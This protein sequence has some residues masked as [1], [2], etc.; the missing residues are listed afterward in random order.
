MALSPLSY[1]RCAVFVTV[2]SVGILGTA[3][4]HGDLDTVEDLQSHI[5]DYAQE[6][7]SMSD[8]VDGIVRDYASG[9][10]V[11]DRLAA[12]VETWEGVEFHEAI[13]TRAMSLYPAIWTALGGLS[14]AVDE[15]GQEAAAEKWQQRVDQALYEGLGALKLVATQK[16]ESTDAHASLAASSDRQGSDI[17]V[18]RENLGTVVEHYRDGDTEAANE[19]LHDTYMQRFEGIEG[20][21]IEQDADLVTDLE[22]DFNGTLPLL[23]EKNA[24][25]DELAKHVETMDTKLERAQTLLDE[26][27]SNQSSVF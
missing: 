21:L 22:R 24:S 16:T 9:E 10:A 7:A 5:D 15:P 12:L 1:L 17:A 23:M 18:I 14:E 25:A 8:T 20:D 13:E 4:A 3:H 6:I 2:A 26:S 27:A 11:G 19:L